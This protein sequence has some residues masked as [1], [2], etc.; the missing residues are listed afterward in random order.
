M[1]AILG[2]QNIAVSTAAASE[3]ISMT[4]TGIKINAKSI[5]G[6]STAELL[7]MM[8]HANLAPE[9]QEHITTDEIGTMIIGQ[10]AAAGQAIGTSSEQEQTS[11]QN[12]FLSAIL[13]IF[14]SNSK[15]EAQKSFFSTIFEKGGDLIQNMFGGLGDLLGKDEADG[16]KTNAIDMFMNFAPGLVDF[17][18]DATVSYT[19]LTLPTILLV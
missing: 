11:S 4:E 8:L 12:L 3:P 19:H 9:L 14:T 13:G 5:D 1:A 10:N 7:S 15:E 17:A 16:L 2:V 18:Y 6:M